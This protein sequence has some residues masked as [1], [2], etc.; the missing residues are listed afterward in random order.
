MTEVLH[1]SGDDLM[2]SEWSFAHR[3]TIHIQWSLSPSLIGAALA[4]GITPQPVYND[5]VLERFNVAGYRRIVELNEYLQISPPSVWEYKLAP[6]CVELCAYLTAVAE[7]VYGVMSGG[8][9]TTGMLR[10]AA[11]W[12]GDVHSPEAFKTDEEALGHTAQFLRTFS[13]KNKAKK[14]FSIREAYSR[15]LLSAKNEGLIYIENQYFRD[16]YFANEIAEIVKKGIIPYIIIITNPLSNEKK[17]F[18]N[19]EGQVAE[20]PTYIAY[21]M[22]K[23][24]RSLSI[25]AGCAP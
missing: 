21:Q 16:S 19:M 1:K 7:L 13:L 4:A 23:K 5:K 6:Q 8:F 9:N 12:N 10:P 25:F 17:E 11:S 20:E 22:L 15:A 2:R 3:F 14:D 18:I 24:G